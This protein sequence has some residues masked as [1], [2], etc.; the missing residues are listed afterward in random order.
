MIY[1]DAKS[2]LRSAGRYRVRG[3]SGRPH[4]HIA[5]FGKTF[6]VEELLGHV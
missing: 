1:A 3:L 5:D 2:K 4:I 6:G